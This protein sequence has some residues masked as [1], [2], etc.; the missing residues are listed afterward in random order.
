MEG[1]LFLSA[2]KY[3]IFLYEYRG[4]CPKTQI[5]DL[6]VEDKANNMGL[7]ESE[8]DS[9]SDYDV[10]LK[11]KVETVSQDKIVFGQSRI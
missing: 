11:Q 10:N 2:E 9:A 1:E 5:S 3:G 8:V 6:K 7:C 4:A